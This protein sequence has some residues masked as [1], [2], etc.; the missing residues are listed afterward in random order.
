MGFNFSIIDPD[1]LG[2]L[3]NGFSFV[4]DLTIK[5]EHRSSPRD[6]SPRHNSCVRVMCVLIGPTIEG[7]G[8][9][10][11]YT[12]V[13]DITMTH[14]TNWSVHTRVS[15][16]IAGIAPKEQLILPDHSHYLSVISHRIIGSSSDATTSD[17]RLYIS[18]DTSAS[19]GYVSGLGHASLAKVFRHVSPSMVPGETTPHALIAQ[20][21]ADALATIEANRSRNGYDNH[22]SGTGIRR[23]TH[24]SPLSG[25]KRYNLFSISATAQLH[26]KSSLQHVSTWKCFDVVELPR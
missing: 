18:F 4:T 16:A 1:Q 11:S 26:V 22:D 15:E 14:E 12:T 13:S 5:K 10:S 23:Q 6:V 7:M 25:S 20:G 19:P 9:P 17:F 3:P 8:S 2:F 21:V 24:G